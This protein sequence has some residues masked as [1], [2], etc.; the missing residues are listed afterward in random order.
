MT[1]Y[2]PGSEPNQ[3]A[4][5]VETDTASRISMDGRIVAVGE[6]EKDDFFLVARLYTQRLCV[7]T[8]RGL[9]S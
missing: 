9:G 1:G 6:E 5:T 2:S 3:D 4:C 8:S 7:V